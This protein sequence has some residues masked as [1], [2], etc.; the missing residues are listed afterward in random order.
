MAGLSG[1]WL[2]DKLWEFCRTRRTVHSMPALHCRPSCF[3]VELV[4]AACP[5]HNTCAVQ[6][7]ADLK[8]L[9]PC[10]CVGAVHLMKRM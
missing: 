6:L 8:Q 5:L 7:L 2:A 1:L 3:S 4:M 10:T 9:C